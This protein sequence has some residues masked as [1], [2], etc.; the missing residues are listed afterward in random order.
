MIRAYTIAD[1]E[2]LVVEESATLL[3]NLVYQTP[4]GQAAVEQY[5][6]FLAEKKNTTGYAIIEVKCDFAG[7]EFSIKTPIIFN[8]SKYTKKNARDF[9]K[10]TTVHQ[11][12]VF[13][14]EI[15]FPC[16]SDEFSYEV[17]NVIYYAEN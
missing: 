15:V 2:R 8:S 11:T 5:L 16:N 1:E 9:K 14:P 10:K 4:V 7:N 3:L 6:P 13:N 12:K 17:V